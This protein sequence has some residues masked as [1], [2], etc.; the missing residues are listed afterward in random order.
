MAQRT[1]RPPTLTPR[2]ATSTLHPRDRHPPLLPEDR[3]WGVKRRQQHPTAPTPRPRPAFAPTNH[4]CQF[5]LSSARHF[6]TRL[7][8]RRLPRDATALRRLRTRQVKPGPVRAWSRS[9]ETGGT[10]A[11]QAIRKYGAVCKLRLR[12]CRE[13]MWRLR[14]AC[15]MLPA[16]H[17]QLASSGAGF[18]MTEGMSTRYLSGWFLS[19][20]GSSRTET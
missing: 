11:S 15:S 14:K 7:P 17:A 13:V 19:P 5:L 6:R 18:M 10:P 12:S 8:R 1:L 20:L 16:A 9:V 3:F 2:R 4:S